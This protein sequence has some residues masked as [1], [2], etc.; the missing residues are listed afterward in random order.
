MPKNIFLLLLL[1]SGLSLKAQEISLQKQVDKIDSLIFYCRFSEGEKEIDRLNDRLRKQEV[2]NDDKEARLRLMLDQAYIYAR[3]MKTSKTLKIS[4][5]IIDLA[6]KYDLPEKEYQ[7]CLMAATMYE[8]SGEFDI[9]KNYLDK[10]YTL[11]KEHHLENV[12]SVYCIRL[13]SYYRFVKE[14]DSAIYY[15]YRGIDYAK[16]Y[17]NRR[18]Y[19]DGCLLLG[20]LLSGKDFNEAVRYS[21]LAAAAFLRKNDYEGAA[22]MYNNISAAYLH[23]KQAD[24]ALL[25]SDSA[26]WVFR[27]NSLPEG[28]YFLRIRY[29]LFDSLGNKDSAY[30]YFKKYH[31][32]Y[33]AVLE[34]KE[35]SEIKKVTEKYENDKKEAVI[36]SKDQQLAFIIA[37]LIVIAGAAALLIRKN[38][39]INVQ[40]KVISRQVEELMK[41]LEQKQILLSELQHRVKNNLQHV[42]SI[43]EIQKESVDFNNIEELIRSNQNRIH[44]MAILHKKLNISESVNDVSLPRYIPELAELVMDSYDHHKK[45]INLEVNCE[46]ET[47]SIE[48]ALPIGL[49]LVELVSNSMKHAFRNRPSGAIRIVLARETGMQENKLYYT[50]NGSGFD[51]DVINDKGLGMEIIRGLIGQLGATAES[52]RDN[53]FELTLRFS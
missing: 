32:A 12:Y 49:I 52:S 47:I 17:N 1:I 41:T 7:A 18:E 35:V 27:T 16:R 21:A 40:N 51:F 14:K 11:Y 39:K 24:K 3:M 13:S 15:A 45:K 8:H 36:K 9:C 34:R 23:H 2:S 28:D 19:I 10:A 5:D 37:L 44:S 26:L 22:A 38:K 48:K 43:L 42:I 33:V 50:D 20:G 29:R 25:Y 6:K 46:I 53:G 30:Y 4:L 31:D